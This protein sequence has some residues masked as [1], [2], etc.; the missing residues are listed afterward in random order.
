MHHYESVSSMVINSFLAAGRSIPGTRMTAKE[1]L[2][3]RSHIPITPDF[4]TPNPRRV[5]GKARAS[6]GVSYVNLLPDELKQECARTWLLDTVFWERYRFE[7]VH[8]LKLWNDLSKIN[9]SAGLD[10]DRIVFTYPARLPRH[11]TPARAI[12]SS[13]RRQIIPRHFSPR[14][15][16]SPPRPRPF[17]DSSSQYAYASSS[18]S[19]SY[20][21]FEYLESLL[22]PL[23]AATPQ[24]SADPDKAWEAFLAVVEGE[25]V[26]I[27]RRLKPPLLMFATRSASGVFTMACDSSGTPAEEMSLRAAKVR[28]ILDT[29]TDSSYPPR[30]ELDILEVRCMALEGRLEEV[31]AILN[32]YC[33]RDLTSEDALNATPIVQISQAMVHAIEI[34]RGPEAAY[35]WLVSRWGTVEQ[36]I[37]TKS[38]PTYS[39]ASRIAV[40]NLR[41]TLMRIVERIENP[42]TFLTDRIR[43]RPDG[44][45]KQAGEHFIDALCAL[46]LPEEALDVLRQMTR[47]SITPSV[48]IRLM[49][50]KA[51]VREK[52]FGLARE[53]YARVCKRMED[54]HKS[55]LREVWSTGLYLHAMEGSVAQAIEDFARLEERGWVNFDAIA[56]VLHATAVKGLVKQTIETFERFFPRAKSSQLVY[57]KPTGTHYTEVLFAH[58]QAGDM[59]RV[60]TWL[61]RMAEDKIVPD[62]Y[63]YAILL[64]GF[65][66]SG[67]HAAFFNLLK[68]MKSS[69]IK[70]N[71][72]GYTTVIALLS[73]T[74]D[75][76]GAERTYQQALKD[77]IKPD[78]KMLNA[79][80]HA[81]VQSGHWQGVV[82]TF[83]YI[84]TLPGKRYRPTT[85]TYNTLLKAHVL[86]GTPFSDIGDMAMEQEALGTRPDAYVYA[87]LVQ[88]AC[89]NKEFDAALGIL[90]H[91][92]RAASKIGSDV[93]VT[94]YV[95]AILMGS[96]LRYGDKV[97]AREMF[98]QMKSRN[99]VPTAITYS[100]IVHAYAKGKTSKSLELAEAFMKQLISEGPEGEGLRAGW[101]S[102]SG[103]RSQALDTLYQPLMHIYAKLR[104]V[105]DVERLHQELLD[106]GGRAS[107]GSLTALLAVY[108]NRGDVEA[109]KETWSLIYDMASQRS[110][111]GDILSSS[112]IESKTNS[113]GSQN[114]ISQS[115]ILCVPLS[116]YIDLLSLTGN[117]AEVARVWDELRTHGFTFD[118]HNWNHLIIALI[119]A[120][121]PERAFAILERVILP[122]ATPAYSAR[123][124]ENGRRPRRPDS[125]LSVVGGNNEVSLPVQDEFPVEPPAWTEVRVHKRNQ[126]VEDARRISKHSEHYPTTDASPRG[127]IAHQ[128]ETLQLIPF[129]WNS[130]RPHSATLS[131]LSQTLTRLASGRLLHPIQGNPDTPGPDRS[132]SREPSIPTNGSRPIPE[133]AKVV[134]NRISAN[135]REA[136]RVVKEFERQEG[137][138]VVGPAKNEQP[139]RWM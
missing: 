109:G 40:M 82:D 98:E 91:M 85:A 123:E 1:L 94:V 55:E 29:I 92:D 57:G 83:N 101:V 79:L 87:L 96:F 8:L 81:H 71:L 9:E 138:R 73:Q 131:V 62:A 117:H 88:S 45:W 74:G 26:V 75:S 2:A 127:D 23:C 103:G 84:K 10:L 34:L 110:K 134:L 115:N 136:V 37:W 70:P 39:R 53:L 124:A 20:N 61:R 48:N 32:G 112:E 15:A 106:Q 139:I 16:H 41:N 49:L 137:E 4:F 99:I 6:S 89:D 38:L 14:I 114:L 122:N 28:R 66:S 24:E 56:L 125:P 54:M 18:T 119:R 68:K 126:R 33:S 7:G 135:Y 11:C 121:E 102:N 58:A 72:Q 128:L 12:P 69:G 3:R 65:G 52:S 130:W 93:K 76:V 50:V 5:K 77:G 19:T 30:Q 67:D 95:L 132:A 118:P 59:D 107:L 86:L 17:S 51:L 31:E 105:E 104:R 90:D 120:G 97:R 60:H 42:G 133:P 129:A 108:R 35:D 21:P 13:R 64:K 36:Y 63:T 111:L 22:R 80:M 100:S 113:D 25:D 43:T 47:L 116:I 44:P 27:P 78:I 46:Q